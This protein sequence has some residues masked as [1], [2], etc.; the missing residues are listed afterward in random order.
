MGVPHRKGL[1]NRR[2]RLRLVLARDRARAR[3]RRRSARR[4]R[5]RSSAGSASTP[6]V[7]HPGVDL[8][9]LHARRR[10]CGALHGPLPR[11]ARRAA[12]ARGLPARGVRA[13]PRASG[14]ARGW[15]L[16]RAAPPASL[17]ARA[18][19][20][21]TSTTTPR[22]LAA[23]REA[24]VCALASEGEAF[25]LVLVEALACGTPAVGSRR[26]RRRRRS[27]APRSRATTPRA[28][29]RAILDA[30]D[31]RPARPAA[32][33]PSASGSTAASPPTRPCIARSLR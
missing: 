32:R 6:R 2:G 20:C 26:R 18:S 7:I 33:A 9:R 21:A 25:G 15:S 30:A 31:E 10:A 19:S 22:S 23:Y 28:L 5:G 17:A 11:R 13:G 27:P 29:A 16:D 4:P 3:D 14:R 8:A 24:H 12:Q 1:A